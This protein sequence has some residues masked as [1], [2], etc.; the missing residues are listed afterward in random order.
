MK[1][2]EIRA[3]ANSRGMK[4]RFGITKIQAVRAI[5]MDEGNH[6]CFAR[7]ESVSCDQEGCVFRQDCLTLAAGQKTR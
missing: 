3:M 1:M 5:Q 2:P 7:A 4:L 6:D